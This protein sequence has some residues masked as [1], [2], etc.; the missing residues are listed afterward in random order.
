[1]L[2]YLEGALDDRRDGVVIIVRMSRSDGKLAPSDPECRDLNA[3]RAA[4]RYSTSRTASETYY[5]GCTGQRLSADDLRG[6]EGCAVGARVREQARRTH[7]RRPLGG[8]RWRLLRDKY[9]ASRRIRA[10]RALAHADR[11]HDDGTSTPPI[12]WH[13]PTS[14]LDRVPRPWAVAREPRSADLVRAGVRG[15]SPQE[16]CRTR[17]ATRHATSVHQWCRVGQGRPRRAPDDRGAHLKPLWRQ[18]VGGDC[19]QAYSRH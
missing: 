16:C 2:Y 14:G 8:K 1:M 5:I 18:H 13:W 17:S 4:C 15:G 11:R 10:M 6:R 19:L 3:A 9:R 7:R 12:T